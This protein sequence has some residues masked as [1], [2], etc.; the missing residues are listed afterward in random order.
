[1]SCHHISL[2]IIWDIVVLTNLVSVTLDHSFHW[3][4]YTLYWFLYNSVVRVIR[5]W[6]KALNPF[7]PQLF[8]IL[9]GRLLLGVRPYVYKKFFQFEVLN[10]IWYVGSSQLVIGD[11]MPYDLIQ[12]HGHGGLKCAKMDDFKGCL[13][14]CA[15]NEK[16]T[17]ELLYLNFNQTVFCIHIWYFNSVSFC[18]IDGS[19]CKISSLAL[20]VCF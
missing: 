9:L 3:C 13:H 19:M 2:K 15:C 7:N 14:Q 12:S 5:K 16:T 20:P 8:I 1:M 18:H 4:L 6:N 17:G 10:E 11:G